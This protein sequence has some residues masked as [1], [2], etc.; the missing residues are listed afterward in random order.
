M[1]SASTVATLGRTPEH[2]SLI[3]IVSLLPKPLPWRET[4]NRA[5]KSLSHYRSYKAVRAYHTRGSG[6][7]SCRCATSHL[8]VCR[9]ILH[10]RFFTRNGCLIPTVD[11]YTLK[12][13]TS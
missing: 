13:R 2:L 11:P 3:D 10:P 5:K 7:V 8:D 1:L 12:A 6:H 4:E 9:L